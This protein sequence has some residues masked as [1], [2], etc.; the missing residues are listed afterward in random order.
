MNIQPLPAGGD[1]AVPMHR[2][3]PL[4]PADGYLPDY[5]VKPDGLD[6]ATIWRLLWERKYLVLACAG[7]G[8]A[9]ALIVSLLQTPLYQS[10][11]TLEL[12]PPTVP[13][14]TGSGDDKNQTMMAPQTDADFLATQYGLLKSK[15][16]AAHVAEDLNL[17]ATTKSDGDESEPQRLNALAAKL[18]NNLDVEP[19]PDSRLVELTYTSEKP[20][21]AAKTVT[22]FANAFIN[23]TLERRYAAAASARKFLEGRLAAPGGE[24]CKFTYIDKVRE[25]RARLSGAL[26]DPPQRGRRSPHASKGLTEP[27]WCRRFCL[28]TP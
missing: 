26:Y 28:T 20:G 14:L 23:S 6:I 21:D 3:H 22:A 5:D 1:S 2:R 12:N 11:A 25:H 8:L 4:V 17:L 18:A 24:P 9:L 13:I 16:L 7:A 27:D 15:S 19:V 10:T